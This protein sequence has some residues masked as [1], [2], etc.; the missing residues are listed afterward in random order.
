MDGASTLSG[1]GLNSILLMNAAPKVL[2]VA[3][4]RDAEQAAHIL[5]CLSQQTYK[6]TML[7]LVQRDQKMELLP[8]KNPPEI[9]TENDFAACLKKSGAERVLFWPEE[10][11]LREAAI[12][13]LV[14]ALQ[15]SPE[16]DG[17]AD[18]ARGST[19]LW[20]AR[21]GET[22]TS[23]ITLW[24]G[25]QIKW[26]EEC[27][28][29][30]PGFFHLAENLS[31]ASNPAELRRP[32][33]IEQF[34][35]KLRFRFENYQ[36]VAIEP[37]WAV[38]V[39]EID[40][41]AVLLLVSRLAA[42]ET[43][44]FILNLVRQLKSQ[45]YRVTIAAT[46]YDT[47]TGSARLNE[48]LQ[49]VPDVFVLCP[50]RPVD[51]PRLIVHLARTR[52]CGRLVI[53][54]CP[55]GYQL[56]P[57]LRSELPTVSFLDYTHLEHESEWPHGGSALRS[58][59]HQSLLDMS[60]VSSQH[61]RQWMVDRGADANGLR[62]CH[63]HI[64]IKKWMPIAEVRASERSALGIKPNTVA[65]LYPCR[66]VEQKRPELMSN[67]AAVLRRNTKVPFVMVVAGDGPLKAAL[68]KFMVEQGLQDFFRLL[69]AVSP[70]RMA[71]LHNA[72]DIL[73]LP[74]LGETIAPALFEAMALESVPVAADVGGQRELVTPDC[75]YLIPIRDAKWEFADYVTVLRCLLENRALMREKASACRA[76]LIEH[77][78]MGQATKSFVSALEEAGKRH[79]RHPVRLPD[80]A[81]FREVA[82]LAIDQIRLN[83][84]ALVM[85]EM[86]CM[87]EEKVN[88]QEK[89]IA[90]L[91][92][93]I[94][95]ECSVDSTP[96]K[97]E[98]HC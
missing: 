64:D 33:A 26:I 22:M 38:P 58:V 3:R 21:C 70:E 10:G 80:A 4:Y 30:K 46:A 44:D 43:G 54:H 40:D 87:L 12:E 65:I 36:P 60:V 24:F 5:S 15:L 14:I 20:L 6:D 95:A 42:E 37:L 51:L 19:G 34:F 79:A 47:S 17:V 91:R 88:K 9:C 72:S 63:T 67:I 50:P 96:E 53:C 69:D 94:K 74:S 52:R 13:K 28:R 1:R 77:F 49:I 61:L 18:A 75:G 41:R 89:I 81:V 93:E 55:L 2:V 23:L 32:Y 83:H 97:N 29:H 16:Q 56:L 57:W 92:R 39:G 71:R 66:L 85:R 35:G 78:Q 76:R 7:V 31:G 90:K 48:L 84:E 82:T 27:M 11:D 73:L 68:E 59:N 8:D 45:G 86:G 25:P 98:V 62:V